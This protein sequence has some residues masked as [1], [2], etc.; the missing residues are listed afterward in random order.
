[1]RSLREFSILLFFCLAF[2]LVCSEI[3]ETLNLYDDHSNDFVGSPSGPRAGAVTIAHQV[4]VS[5]RGS[6]IADLASRTPAM[7]PSAEPV[8]PSGRELLRLL[9]IQRK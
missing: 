5:R 7:I 8:V 2:G 1:M 9:S 6:T 4:V 3:P